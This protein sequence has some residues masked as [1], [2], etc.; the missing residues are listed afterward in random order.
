MNLLIFYDTTGRKKI[1]FSSKQAGE[2]LISGRGGG[3]GGGG[4]GEGLTN[5]CMFVVV[6]VGYI[7]TFSYNRL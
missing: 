2:G 5:A 3:G 4:G 1:E 7:H 6:V